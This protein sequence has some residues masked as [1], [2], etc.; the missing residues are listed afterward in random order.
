VVI[1]TILLA[2]H[3]CV[4]PN[5]ISYGVLTVEGLYEYV[6]A[7][8]HALVTF[9]WHALQA[10]RLSILPNVI[11]HWF[12]IVLVKWASSLGLTCIRISHTIFPKLAAV[13]SQRTG[14][15]IVAF[16]PSIAIPARPFVCV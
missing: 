4:S 2:R 8:N 15:V 11:N 1:L 9:M 6:E 3:H 13:C 14:L 7:G 12:V 10:G 16:A 5:A